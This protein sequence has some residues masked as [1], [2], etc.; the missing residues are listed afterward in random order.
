M[1]LFLPNVL[2]MI[3]RA[4]NEGTGGAQSYLLAKLSSGGSWTENI[5]GVAITVKVKSINTST[6]DAVL[7][8]TQAGSACSTAAPTPAPT[9]CSINAQCEDGNACTENVCINN[10]CSIGSI[11]QGNSC[12]DSN[13]CTAGDVCDAQGTCAGTVRG[14]YIRFSIQ[15]NLVY[16]IKKLTVASFSQ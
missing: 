6:G 3:T 4:G 8:V 1:P 16:H 11:F 5:N 7:C 15:R 12:D 10:Q 13:P 2:V 14:H 9:A